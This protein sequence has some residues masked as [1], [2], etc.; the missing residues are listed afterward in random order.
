MPLGPAKSQV[1][2]YVAG[3]GT[4]LRLDGL[5]LPGGEGW[6]NED[7]ASLRVIACTGS[8]GAGRN[9][10]NVYRMVE[11]SG[12]LNLGTVAAWY[13]NNMGIGTVGTMVGV[14]IFAMVYGVGSRKRAPNWELPLA[15]EQPWFNAWAGAT[16][17]YRNMWFTIGRQFAT[18][19]GAGLQ[20]SSWTLPQPTGAPPL[21]STMYTGLGLPN[22]YDRVRRIKEGQKKESE[23]ERLVEEGSFRD[24]GS[25]PAADET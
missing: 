7:R 6:K 3:S 20:A 14:D 9:N 4:Q 1:G 13:P 19:I 23:P 22:P 21:L 16:G 8:A 11:Y 10:Q 15:N 5:S 25:A 12:G 24:S 2:L 18:Y 17:V